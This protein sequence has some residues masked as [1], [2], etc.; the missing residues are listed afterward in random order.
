MGL[1]VFFPS[2]K[3]KHVA[4]NIPSL[5]SDKKRSTRSLYSEIYRKQKKKSSTIGN[6]R[7]P[8]EDQRSRTDA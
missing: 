3:K 7:N 5:R 1:V 2:I 6:I 8:T 4:R